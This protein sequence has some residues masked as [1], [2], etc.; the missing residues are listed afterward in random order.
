VAAPQAGGGRL[1][2]SRLA[3]EDRGAAAPGDGAGVDLDCSFA[4][5]TVLK[6]QLVQRV[7]ERPGRSTLE[8]R[9]VQAALPQ[10]FVDHHRLVDRRPQ[11][12]NP[13]VVEELAAMTV[14]PPDAAGVEEQLAF[15]G[16]WSLF[17]K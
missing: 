16:R 10:A 9:E 15:W 8:A 17:R 6:E 4:N 1:A 5:E 7:V 11:P 2:R 12:R 3:A 14:H 13:E